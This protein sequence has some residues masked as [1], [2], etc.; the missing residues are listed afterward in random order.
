MDYYLLLIRLTENFFCCC[1]CCCKHG[2]SVLLNK[3]HYPQSLSFQYTTSTCGQYRTEKL[4]V[5]F[6]FCSKF[7]KLSKKCFQSN[8]CCFPLKSPCQGTHFRWT[9]LL[10]V[11]GEVS[12]FLAVFTLLL[13]SIKPFQ[14][15]IELF[16]QCFTQDEQQL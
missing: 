12:W 8:S 4:G 9:P 3:P 1:C 10:S 14:H 6:S 7:A 2:Q 11:Q 13:E 15:Q 5:H 16:T